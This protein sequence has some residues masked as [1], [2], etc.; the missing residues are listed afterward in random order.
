VR[1]AGGRTGSTEE[2]S[3]MNVR[4]RWQRVA[5]LALLLLTF[6]IPVS[7][8]S[9]QTT[10]KQ[11]A[12]G[13]GLGG[14]QE[15]FEAK[16]NAPTSKSGANDFA[17]GVKYKVSG[18]KS[19]FVYWHGGYSA[20]IVLNATSGWSEKKAVDIANR[21]L[22]TDVQDNGQATELSDKSVLIPG[23][24]DALGKRFSAKTYKTYGVGG[25]QGDLRVLLIPNKS[26]SE[27]GTIDI[28]IGAGDE[29]SGSTTQTATKSTTK[30]TTKETPTPKAKTGSTDEATYLKT[31]RKNVD[32][33]QKSV[34]DFSTL[35]A[36]GSNITDAEYQDLIGILT[37]W[38]AAPSDASALTAPAGYEDLQQAYEGAANDLSDASLNLTNYLANGGKDQSLLTEAS[39]KLKSAKSELQQADQL[40]TDAGY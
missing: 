12:F 5:A 18:Y 2:K 3:L 36:K 7:A 4:Y 10:D 30:T 33:L 15:T 25:D 29:L 21:F 14:S 26:G 6:L 1:R 32:D 35:I 8:A 39:A 17:K 9:A 16:Y 22:P 23:H 24:S 34:D 31:V 38:L 28:A 40:L 37:Q 13:V 11:D 20:H 27:V 19:V